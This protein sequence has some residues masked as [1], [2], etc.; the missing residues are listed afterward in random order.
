MI[1]IR[2]ALQLVLREP[3]RSLAAL[4]GVAIASALVTSVLLFGTASGTTVT[5][6]ALANLPVDA[7]V[8]LS[9]SSDPAAAL[10]IVK[11]DPS[12]RAVVPFDLAHFLN[13]ASTR[14]GTA[15][16]T[17][18]GVLV[19]ID[20]S[21]SA[22]TGLFTLSSGSL[23]PGSVAI[24]RD[25]ASNL[26]AVPGDTITFALPG[27][28]SATF[29]VSGIVSTTGADL[30]LGPVDPAHRTAGANPPTNVA[31]LGRPGPRPGSRRDPG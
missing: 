6:R 17:S 29:K 12:V 1:L 24:S 21:Y 22:T 27:G 28:A 18:G 7:Q 19:G 9:P 30:V 16:Q 4:I 11:S 25:L 2:H 23:E 5:R 13:A 14:A 15:T 31:V 3:R 26:G 10:S 20:P 8:E